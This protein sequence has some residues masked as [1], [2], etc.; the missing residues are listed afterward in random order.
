M[1]RALVAAALFGILAIGC[2]QSHTLGGDEVL[3]A[4]AAVA[5]DAA[6]AAPDGGPPEVSPGTP[7]SGVECGPNRCLVGE[8]CCNAEC[9]VCAFEAECVDHGCL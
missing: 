4:D 8:V 5:L 2:A 3:A 7:T 6:V 1:S 9:G